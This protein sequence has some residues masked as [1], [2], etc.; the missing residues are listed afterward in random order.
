MARRIEIEL[1]SARPDGTWTW[2]A[3]GALNP[4]GTLDGS[5]LYSKAKAGDV[6][7]AEAEFGIDGITVVSVEPPRTPEVVDPNRIELIE[8]PGPGGVTTQLGGGRARTGPDRP[9]DKRRQ[10]PASPQPGSPPRR[11]TAGAPSAGSQPPASGNGTRGHA[12]VVADGGDL[13]E[14]P[15]RGKRAERPPRPEG[16]GRPSRPGAG[17]GRAA[18]RRQTT[19][20]TRPGEEAVGP[21]KRPAAAHQ[22]RLNPGNTH[23]NAMLESL[24]VEQQPIAQQLLRGGIPA[25]RTALHFERERAREAGRPEPSTE[26]VLA[27]AESLV[28]RVK[29]AEW[30]DRA[31]AAIKAGDDLAMRDLRSLVS[32]SDVAR[33]EA[34]RELVVTLRE[35]LERRIEAH[36]VAWADDV[37]KSLDQGQVVR[38]LRIASRPPDASARF[39]AELATRLRDAASSA[40]SPS[41]PADQWLAVLQ[42]VVESPVRRTVKPEGLPDNP[43]PELLEA[44]RQH[45]GRVPA[46]A[47]LLG[48][49]VPP[50]PGPVRPNVPVRAP[51]RRQTRPRRPSGHR[52]PPVATGAP[53][54][55][56]PGTSAGTEPGAPPAGQV[57]A[58]VANAV[59]SEEPAP[60]EEPAPS[61]DAVS[62]EGPASIEGPVGSE[63]AVP[64]AEAA[65]GDEA[66]ATAEPV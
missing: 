39:S 62:I 48:I 46:L 16:P 42:A 31:E 34:S 55:V 25:V 47:P 30:R 66:V 26:G 57:E 15:E 24:P 22:R 53:Q 51:S 29:A 65:P 28:S 54:G 35:M 59:Q 1:T 63:E 10:R 60:T 64:A 61:E 3:A 13:A 49:S 41:T 23:R 2:R 12:E 14:K 37:A 40:L 43:S 17:P 36:R 5:L 52:T 18:P 38:A 6:V 58:D 32:G 9:D 45:C 7:R 33:D 21:A 8:R 20:G 44:A 50:P 27:L 4:R 56:E 19:R 11:P